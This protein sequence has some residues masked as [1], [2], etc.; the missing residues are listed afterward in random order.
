MKEPG[1][2][3]RLEADLVMLGALGRDFCGRLLEDSLREAGV[4][5]SGLLWRKDE[6]TGPAMITVS[7]SG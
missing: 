2:R 1:L 6:E 5:V 4:D 3:S 7:R